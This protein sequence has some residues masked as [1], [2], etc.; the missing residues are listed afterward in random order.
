M[1][2]H[3]TSPA[4]NAFS[5]LL[6]TSLALLRALVALRAATLLRVSAH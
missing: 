5:G 3:F 4:I 1:L 2:N 6:L